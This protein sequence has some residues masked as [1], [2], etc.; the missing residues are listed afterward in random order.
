MRSLCLP[1]LFVVC[2][3]AC[4]NGEK[5]GGVLN[6][7][8]PS[9]STPPAPS[10]SSDSAIFVGA[11]D[12]AQC[13][14]PSGTAATTSLVEQ[15]AQSGLVF[16]TGDNVY[17]YGSIELYKECFDKYWGRFKPRIRPTPGNHDLGADLRGEPGY[18]D[19]FGA[20]AGPAGLG[21]Y[22]FEYGS[23]VAFALNSETSM[24]Q[25]SP[26]WTWLE[27]ELERYR[28]IK[29]Q[30]AYWHRPLFTSGFVSGPSPDTRPLW[31]LL[32]QYKVELILN[33]HEHLYE[34]F[35]PQSPS[36]IA[37]PLGIRQFTVGTGGMTLY[38][39]RGGSPNIQRQFSIHGI[40]VLTLAE[41]RY[42]WQFVSINNSVLDDSA[43]QENLCNF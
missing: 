23:W 21:Y 14:G 38:P 3:L 35:A 6:P 41:D 25:G 5:K 32:Y 7:L 12:I 20:V 10:V 1:M 29:C 27:A 24:R 9:P 33:G 22:S 17:P 43:G 2:S 30:I 37:D 40:L 39:F 26:Q 13:S 19:Y 42:D 8:S 28:G 11:G 36:G 15:Y 16:T 4:S 18:F 34:R 31:N